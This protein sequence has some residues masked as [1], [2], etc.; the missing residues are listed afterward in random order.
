MAVVL[1]R[2][3]MAYGWHFAWPMLTRIDV[4]L[5]LVTVPLYRFRKE[6]N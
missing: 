2:F 4:P 5:P 6:K 3:E 1:V